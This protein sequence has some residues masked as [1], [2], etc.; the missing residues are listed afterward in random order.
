MAT[1][2]YEADANP[3]ALRDKK[4]AVM[5]Y[6]SQGHAHA[7]NLKE[8]GFDVRVG[9]YEGSRSWQKAQDDGLKVMSVA[10]AAAEADV[11]MVLVPDHIQKRLYNEAIAAG[12]FAYN[13]ATA[14]M[15][16]FKA[17]AR[18]AFLGGLGFINDWAEWQREQRRLAAEEQAGALRADRKLDPRVGEA[19][20]AMVERTYRD[21][22]LR[23]A[24][25]RQ[26]PVETVAELAEGRVWSGSDALELKL[27]DGYGEVPDAVEAAAELAGLGENYQ[28][29]YL[30]P[31]LT[32]GQYLL[33]RIQGSAIG[34]RALRSLLPP[35]FAHLM[36]AWE[37]A[38]QPLIAPAQ[39]GIYAFCLCGRPG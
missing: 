12:M 2:Y 19:I 33:A 39:R 37:A 1:I 26:L 28:A 32:L 30:E 31:E 13:D 17:N 16:V 7:L 18:D 4:I 5:G 21:F 10:D 15:D 36:Q 22:L 8:S 27:V 14:G 24:D 34:A 35:E 29:R 38:A 23:V 6:G 11:I 3:E 25:A 20:Q 9:L